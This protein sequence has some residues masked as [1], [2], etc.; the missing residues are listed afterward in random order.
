MSEIK[1]NSIKGVGASAAAIT[2]NN[3]DGTCTANIT[4]NLSNRNKIINGAMQVAQRGTST[5]SVTGI[6]YFACD[7]QKTLLLS[8]GTWTISQSTEAPSDN[9]FKKSMKYD[10]TTA[11]S[12]LGAN[13][14]LQHYYRIE[15][16]DLQ[17]VCKGTSSAKPL[18]LSFWVKTN[19]TGTYNVEVIDQ[20]NSRLCSKS[21]TVSDSNWNKYTLVFPA[22]TTGAFNDDN[23]VSLD[24]GWWLAAGSTFSTGSNQ[25]SF[26][27]FVQANRAP[28]NVN[29]ADS[30]SNEWYIT[31]IQLEIDQTGSGVATDFEH[32][33]FGQELALCQRYYELIV[34]RDEGS[35]AKENCIGLFWGDGSS[36]LTWIKFHVKKRTQPTLDVSNFTNAFRM[37]GTGGGVNVST[38]GTNTLHRDG[39]LLEQSGNAGS[40]GFTRTFT[41]GSDGLKAIVAASAEL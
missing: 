41:D 12:S 5:S 20:D 22:D 34:E 1:V 29:L 3:T 27:S 17:D 30:T 13:D 36:S 14:Y 11:D 35:N 28:S 23:G 37:Y 26:G 33:S 31:G 10:C 16:Q 19:K 7:R 6:G 2:V 9:G 25:T 18:I 40:S 4:N 32:R 39:M 24:I 15:G 21:Y 8:A 38:L